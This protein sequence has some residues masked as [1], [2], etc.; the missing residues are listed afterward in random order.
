MGCISS[1]WFSLKING[2]LTGFLQGRSGIR[3]GDPLSPYIFVLG[4]EI[5][6]RSLRRVCD[7]PQV[8]YHPKC[9]KIKLTHLIFADDLMIFIRGDVPSISAVT[10]SLQKFALLSGLHANNE[11]T[12][13]YFGGVSNCQRDYS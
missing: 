13:I 6:S 11:K 3:Q 7:Q 1:P 4:M 9:S 2:E 8:S 10:D 5:L 12:S